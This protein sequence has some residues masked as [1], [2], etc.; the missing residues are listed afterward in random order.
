MAKESVTLQEAMA[1]AR[2]LGPKGPIEAAASAGPNE[3]RAG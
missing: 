1:L 3:L 2:Q